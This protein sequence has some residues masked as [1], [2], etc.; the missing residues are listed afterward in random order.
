MTLTDLIHHGLELRQRV[1]AGLPV[2]GVP[3]HV[4]YAIQRAEARREYARAMQR[5][6]VWG[7]RGPSL[8][9]VAEIQQEIRRHA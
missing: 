5:P 7:R 4:R 9:V 8:D 2:P 6:S 3:L 1:V